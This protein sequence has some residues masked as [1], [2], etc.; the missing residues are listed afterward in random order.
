M[1][2]STASMT[3]C[4]TYV[5]PDMS[6]KR[7]TLTR[8]P[9]PKT[10]LL[11]RF[12]ESESSIVQP[13]PESEAESIGFHNAQFTWS[14]DT[15]VAKFQLCILGTLRFQTGHMNLIVGPTGTHANSI[16]QP[17]PGYSLSSLY[18]A[19]CG[20]DLDPDGTA[21]GNALPASHT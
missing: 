9:R 15:S 7:V 13:V 1:Y 20:Q 10:E 14:E 5:H 19:R 4:K 16:S 21:R 6:L 12:T 3:F 8:P 17:Y 2:R 11:D 18:C